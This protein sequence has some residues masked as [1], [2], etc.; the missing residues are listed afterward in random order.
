MSLLG[1]LTATS[2]STA[3]LAATGAAN[4]I[5]DGPIYN[6]PGVNPFFLFDDTPSHLVRYN[7]NDFTG[8][9]IRVQKIVTSNTS[10][11][12]ATTVAAGAAAGTSPAISVVGNDTAGKVSVTMGTSPTSGSLFTVTFGVAYSSAPKSIQLTPASSGDG[13]A[14]AY[15]SSVATGSFGVS[16]EAAASGTV[17]YYY[18]VA[19]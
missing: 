19:G 8:A 17:S 2:G 14:K 5:F 6:N 3:M 10:Q 12:A 15:V 9:G 7:G 11:A 4:M 16:V 1:T 13:T 18:F